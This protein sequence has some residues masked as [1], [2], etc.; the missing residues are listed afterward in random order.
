MNSV[1]EKNKNVIE[2]NFA[3]FVNISFGVY[4]KRPFYGIMKWLRMSRLPERGSL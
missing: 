2:N 3:E 1:D 4:T